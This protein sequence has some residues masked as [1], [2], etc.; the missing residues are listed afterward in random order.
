MA[1]I[2]GAESQALENAAVGAR[3]WDSSKVVFL[4]VCLVSESIL[5]AFDRSSAYIGVGAFVYS[6]LL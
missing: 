1:S 4:V 6:L 5:L 3:R 2:A